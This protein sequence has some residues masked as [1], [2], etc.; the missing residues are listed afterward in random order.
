[1]RFALRRII[2]LPS[3]KVTHPAIALRRL[4]TP[5]GADSNASGK[6]EPAPTAATGR[7]QGVRPEPA[8]GLDSGQDEGTS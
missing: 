7:A 3:F 2:H 4:N 1:M 6:G 5:T 8:G